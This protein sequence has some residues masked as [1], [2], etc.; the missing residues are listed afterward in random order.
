MSS[1]CIAV[2]GMHR[3]GTSLVAG[4]IRA[5][6]VSMGDYM[7]QANRTN[8]LGFFEDLEYVRFHQR[9]FRSHFKGA[10]VGH[11]DWGWTPMQAINSNDATYLTQDAKY[12]IRQRSGSETIWG[13]K[14]P[15]TTGSHYSHHLFLLEFIENQLALPTRYIA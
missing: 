1:S 3:S 13:F 5:L 9:L 7:V 15:R 12:L 6:G 11:P 10:K 2:V 8:P 4:L 14:D